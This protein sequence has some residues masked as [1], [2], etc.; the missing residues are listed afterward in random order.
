MA[1]H[2][3]GA[4]K[5]AYADF[6]TAMMAF[7]MVMWLVAQPQ[8]VKEAVAGYF[9]DPWGTSS[10]HDRPASLLPSETD[11]KFLNQDMLNS[12]PRG[13]GSEENVDPQ[14]KSKWAQKRDVRFLQDGDRNTPAIVVRFDESS[15]ELSQQAQDQFER[16]IPS[17]VGKLNKIEVRG[18]S[19]RR[20]LPAG[21][22]Y[23]DLWQLCYVRCQ[24]T[25]DYLVEHGIE[26]ERLRLSQ[27]AAFDPVTRRL[28]SS[29]QQENS[30]VEVFL[31]DE[32]ADEPPGTEPSKNTKHDDKPAELG[33]SDDPPAASSAPPADSHPPDES[34]AASAARFD[35]GPAEVDLHIAPDSPTG[36]PAPHA[37]P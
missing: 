6:V 15:A 21:S 4:W 19:T 27:S 33:V 22:P 24:A 37:E 30:R 25:M 29:W 13:G 34:P 2:G 35:N 8:E 10:E 28:E 23:G 3:G 36:E 18:H 9:Q 11:G 1:G 5:V 20:P 14:S 17:L 26:P 7:F 31:L 12:P 16:L 32:L